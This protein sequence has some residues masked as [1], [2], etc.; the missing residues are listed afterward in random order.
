MGI[1][2]LLLGKKKDATSL[3]IRETLFGDMPL[4]QFPNGDGNSGQFPWSAF[5]AA[6]HDLAEGRKSDAFAKWQGLA[7]NV[8]LEPRV[9]LQAWH[10]LR[11]HGQQPP[12]EAA[13]EL[14]GVVVEVTLDEGLDLLAAYPD[15]SARYYNY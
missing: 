13:K 9:R 6:R 1:L 8:E 11:Q 4:D 5:I 3:L 10:F 12:P 15:H 14:L 2:N 7:T